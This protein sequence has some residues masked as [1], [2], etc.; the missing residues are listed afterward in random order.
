MTIAAARRRAVE[1]DPSSTD[2]SR[3]R[4]LAEHRPF[5][6]ALAL[7]AALRVV[8]SLAFPPALMVSDGPTYLSFLDTFE[9]DPDRPVGYGV[10]LLY[11]VYLLTEAVAAVAAVQHVLGL[12]TGVLIYVLLRRWDVGR[13]PAT[14]A[15]LPVLFDSLQLLL[16]HAPLSDTLFV[17]LVTLGVVAL[18][19]RRRPTLLLALAAGLLLGT[20]ATVRQVGLPLVLAGA[21]YCLLVGHGWRRRVATALVLAVGFAAPVGAYAA[22]YE[23]EH[24]VY[25]L[26][27]IGGKSVYMRTTP[28]VDCSRLSV[29]DY[30]QVL[31]PPEPVGQRLDPTNYGWYDDGTVHRLEPPSG[32]SSDAAMRSFAREAIR[33]QPVD[34]AL[35][36]ARDFAL[37]FDLWRGNRFEFDTAFKWRFDTYVDREP[38]SWT[39]PAFEAHGGEQQGTRQPYADALVA[40]QHVGYLPGPLL[41]GCLVLGLSGGLGIGRARGSG[42]RSMCL[43]LTVSGAGLLLV[44]DVTTQFVWRYQ[45]PGLVLLPAGAALAFTALTR[46]R[47]TERGISATPRTD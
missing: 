12:A 10:L 3:T 36:V 30:Q 8:V 38:S 27:G 28:F 24:G 40:Y 7:A 44:P 32:T 46:R 20:S 18:G 25:A 47:H 22:W 4:R 9:P 39:G 45:L 33:E 23:Q 15:T 2:P 21:A 19:W 34:Y 13:W 11:P 17:L 1:V 37:N 43:L 16:E 14:L 41:L 31:C 26:S 5:L 42:V 29:P 6:V 35:V